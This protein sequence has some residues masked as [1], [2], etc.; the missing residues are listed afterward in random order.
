[1]AK[2]KV[3]TIYSCQNCGAQRS[4]WEGRCSDCGAWNTMVEETQA[5]EGTRGWVA[6]NSGTGAPTLKTLAL[7]KS[8]EALN[9]QRIS[10]RISEFDR[11]LGGGLVKGSLVL[12]GGS[13]GIGKST[14][15]LQA[16]SGLAQKKGLVLYV[17]AEESVEQTSSRAHRLNIRSTQ[18]HISSESNLHS[19]IALA[20]LKSWNLLW[21]SP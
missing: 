4:K 8:P 17:S 11:V 20:N 1:M 2:N 14:L 7:D 21:I 16:C 6:G 12:L 13:P 5:A 15:L 18:I 9:I 3:R 19:I 10:T